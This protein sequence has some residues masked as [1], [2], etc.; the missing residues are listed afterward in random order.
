MSLKTVR[1]PDAMA[2]VFGEAER[3]VASYFAAWQ[4]E[5][6]RGTIEIFG[7]RYVLVRAASLSVEFFGL[8]EGLYGPG[9]EEEAAAFARNILFDLAHAIGKA[10]ARSFHAKMG[11][12]DPIARLSAGPVHFSH[13]GWAFVD[14]LEESVAVPDD[15]YCL[16]YDHPYSFE[17]DAWLRAQRSPSFPVCIMN[18][19]Y[20]SGWCEE[21]FDMVLVASE[22]LCRARGDEHCRFVMST[23][24]AIEGHVRAYREDRPHLARSMQGYQ[25]PDFF[26]RKRAEEELRHSHD[27]LE[28]R[29]EDRTAELSRANE[30]LQ[31]EMEERVRAESALRQTHKLEALGRLAGGIA[32]DFNNLM[33]VVLGR[34]AILRGHLAPDDPL[35]AEVEEIRSAGERAA[36]LTQQLLAFSRVQVL[37]RVL[38]DLDRTVDDV[39]GVLRP[40]LP[41]DIEIQ[42][43]PPLPARGVGSVEVDRGQI[44]QVVMNLVINARDAMPAG[45]ILTV[46]TAR[47]D[48]AARDPAA[49]LP[50]GEYACLSVSDTGV[51]MSPET[52]AHV[53]EPFFTTKD[54]GLGAGLGL[55]TVY[56]IVKQSGGG[57]TVLSEPRQGSRF[58]VYLPRSDQPASPV[59]EPA[60]APV[61]VHGSETILLVEDRQNLRTVLGQVLEGFGYVVLSAGGADEAIDLSDRHAGPIHLL[62]TDVVMPRMGGADLARRI[63]E[64]RPE[65]SVLY[66][67]GHASDAVVRH[68]VLERASG[69]LQKPFAPEQL[70]AKIREILG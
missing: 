69:F 8:V 16:I 57:I 25:I 63:A 66:M 54:E 52:M 42:R 6:E 67:S 45:G 30:L 15:T 41:E 1:V 70:A 3:V 29:V 7:E 68:G 65:V 38:L 64:R 17:S 58:S 33:G 46:E 36:V 13:T 48:A 5:P 11:L 53:F 49:A 9:R 44:E 35:R 22:V 26:S 40:L 34:C 27:Q 21:S 28:R 60:T 47:V 14:I 24:G 10:D 39:L 12:A 56:G 18:A 19:G 37:R 59:D 55:A 51:G 2:S 50:A 23:P 43:V 61:A 20:S 4:K 32:H 62:L 31:R